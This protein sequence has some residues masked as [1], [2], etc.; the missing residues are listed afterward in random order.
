MCQY[1][2][3]PVSNHTALFNKCVCKPPPLWLSLEQQHRGWLTRLRPVYN[4]TDKSPVH[5]HGRF[6]HLHRLTTSWPFHA[7]AP[8]YNT[9]DD[10]PVRSRGWFM[11]PRQLTTRRTTCPPAPDY[12]VAAD[13]SICA[14]SEAAVV[15]TVRLS[16]PGLYQHI[17][18]H[19]SA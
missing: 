8:A 2:Q 12:N 13:S 17:G 19:L 15:F 1:Y 9:T 7:F 10:S 14:A 16:R 4:T 6:S 5:H 3:A 11:R 18:P